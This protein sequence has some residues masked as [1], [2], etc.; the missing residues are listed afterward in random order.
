MLIDIEGYNEWMDGSCSSDLP[1]LP[2][3]PLDNATS[4]DHGERSNDRRRPRS[5]TSA[6]EAVLEILRRKAARLAQKR[7]PSKN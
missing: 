3:E 4:S 1:A 5:E 6:K 7:M 2:D